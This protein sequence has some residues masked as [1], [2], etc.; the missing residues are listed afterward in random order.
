MQVKVKVEWNDGRSGS[1]YG[2]DELMGHGGGVID[3]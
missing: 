3:K 2:L 1:R